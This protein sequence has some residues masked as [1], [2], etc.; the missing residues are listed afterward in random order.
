MKKIFILFSLLLPAA[1]AAQPALSISHLAGGYYVYTTYKDLGGYL[2]PS[3]SMYLV[4]EKG[5]VLIDTPWDTTQFQPLL[6]SIAR[7]HGQPVVMCVATHYHDDRTAG[8]EFF[9]ERG[10]AT[11]SSRYTGELCRDFGEKRAEFTF[12]NDTVFTI[13]GRRLETFY[14]GEGH[15]RDNIVIW[16]PDAKIIFGGC[17]V[18]SVQSRSLGNTAD[19]NLREWGPS[20]RRVMEKYPKAKYV[21]PGHFGWKSRKALKH[22]LKLLINNDKR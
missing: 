1:L 10:V 4:T 3:N 8:L 6:D 12:E 13:G 17:L 14:P 20:V 7:R 11:W 16:I 2:F 9:R 22:T 5:V 21:I 19:A 15:S 18:K